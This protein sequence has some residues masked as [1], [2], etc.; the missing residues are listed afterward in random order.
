[1]K[2]VED[3]PNNDANVLHELC[4]MTNYHS[5]ECSKPQYFNIVEGFT[6]FS[7]RLQYVL[8]LTVV[9]LAYNDAGLSL[10]SPKSANVNFFWPIK[11]YGGSLFSVRKNTATLCRSELMYPAVLSI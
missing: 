7:S 4:E 11:L 10:Y 2:G 8:L 6:Q 5:P 1:M 9:S 3:T